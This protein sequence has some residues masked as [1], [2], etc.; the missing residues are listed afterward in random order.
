MVRKFATAATLVVAALFVLGV[1]SAF[2]E[3]PANVT[4]N[5]NNT[6]TTTN[7]SNN[8]N[9]SNNRVAS[10]NISLNCVAINAEVAAELAKL[11]QDSEAA[12]AAQNTLTQA[13]TQANEDEAVL[14]AAQ[15]QLAADIAA[16]KPKAT[17]DQDTAAVQAAQLKVDQD[18]AQ[19]QKDEAAL[20][21]AQQAVAFD[22]AALTQTTSQ[23]STQNVC[24]TTNVVAPPKGDGGGAGAGAGTPSMPNTGAQ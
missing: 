11:N 15:K 21:N 22:Q 19:I 24:T 16:A 17:I 3:D 10:P 20:K 2:A 1:S 9:N 4:V 8:G 14:V 23:S 5:K 6:T 12:N 18:N 13:Q 7:N